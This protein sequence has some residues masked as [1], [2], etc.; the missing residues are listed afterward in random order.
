MEWCR[1][2]FADVDLGDQ[3]LNGRLVEIAASLL[4]KPESSLTKS[5]QDSAAVRGAG[6]FFSNPRFGYEDML[7]P[8][9]EKTL[10]RFSHED[11][12]LLLQDTSHLNFGKHKATQGLGHVGTAHGIDHQGIMMHSALAV[13][14]KGECFGLLHQKLWVRPEERR[15][16][17][18]KNSHQFVPFEEKESF[19]WVDGLRAVDA[20]MDGLEKKPHLIWVADREADVYEHLAEMEQL[21]HSFVIR[22]NNDR[23]VDS[24]ERYLWSTLASY[25]S[26]GVYEIQMR[27]EDGATHQAKIEVRFGPIKLLAQRRQK[28]AHQGKLP[29]LELFGI[30]AREID[31][32]AGYEPIE[33]GLIT[34]LRVNT[35]AD[36]LKIIG[37]YEKRWHIECFHKALK[38]GFKAED[39]RL[40]S[41]DKLMKF[42]T[43]ASIL[44]TRLYWAS[45][46]RRL[47][48]DRSASDIL[49]DLEWRLLHAKANPKA[50]SPARPPTVHEATTWIAQLGGFRGTYKE[51]GMIVYWRGWHT[52]LNMVEGAR[53]ASRMISGKDVS[54]C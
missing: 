35:L 18:K 38:S 51:P 49:S 45:M 37:Y 42:I 15:K 5:A 16:G 46:L 21:R 31:P 54:Y 6:R 9:C 10:E 27:D 23:I 39:C 29:D 11:V 8:H 26:Q 20:L 19:K 47:D 36:A 17:A 1:D 3:R 50:K 33:W 32:P 34:S 14:D 12:V 4:A 43:L 44:A 24:D 22:I 41:A 13:S 7:I 2:E 40:D 53:I 25:A 48:P 30:L 52:L 28:G